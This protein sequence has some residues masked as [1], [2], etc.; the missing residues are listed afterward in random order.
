[1]MRRLLARLVDVYTHPGEYP[2]QRQY[3]RYLEGLDQATPAE[4]YKLTT[5]RMVDGDWIARAKE[6]DQRLRG[7]LAEKGEGE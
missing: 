3:R 4:P 1:M 7:E 6:R 5:V 2:T